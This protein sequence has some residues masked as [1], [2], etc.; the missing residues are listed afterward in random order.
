MILRALIERLR[1]EG[2]YTLVAVM[3]IMA[4]VSALSVATLASTGSDFRPG[5]ADKERKQAY[6]AAEA[7]VN[8]YLSRLVANPD[9]WRRCATDPANPSLNQVNPATR[10]WASIPTSV[11]RYSVELLPANGQAACNPD[12]PVG[13]FIDSDTGTFRIRSTG[14]PRTGAGPRRS[15]IATFRRRGFLDYIYY[16]DYETSDPQWYR[17][18]AADRPTRENRGT[19]TAPAGRSVVDWGVAECTKYLRDGRENAAFSGSEGPTTGS[20]RLRAGGNAATNADWE[21]WPSTPLRCA[22]IRFVGNGADQDMVNGPL[23]TN[24]D[25]LLC[26]TPHFGRKPTDDIETSGAVDGKGWRQDSGC[27]GTP[28]VNQGTESLSDR[29]TMRPNSPLVTLPQTNAALRD[30]ALPAYRFRGRT[31][32]ILNGANMTVTGKRDNGT[33]LTAASMP[34][35]ADGVIHVAHDTTGTCPGYNPINAYAPAPACGDVWL[36]GT[37]EKNVTINAENDIIIDEDVLAGGSAKPLLGLISNN[38]IRVYHPVSDP[39]AGA[40]CTTTGGPGPVTIEAAILS[41]NHSFAV[42]NWWCGAKIG[43]LTVNGAIGQKYRGLVGSGGAASGSGYLKNYNYN[44]DLRFRSPPRFLD[45][46]QSTWKLKSQVEQVP[47]A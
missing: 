17:R 39:L 46:V 4:A 29:G 24:D 21:A 25:L 37:Y 14:E 43:N 10:S 41:L 26:G 3:G 1:G 19:T 44:N 45:P 11:S 9:Y 38:W 33:V 15:I 8:D 6:A 18:E 28:Q 36:R 31:T 22:G 27:S 42:D 20:G 35:P 40:S 5:A 2:G 16:T 34:I 13:T 47:A 30:D 12:D 32:I 7:G 23:H